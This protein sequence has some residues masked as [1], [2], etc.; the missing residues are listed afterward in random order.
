[1]T[2]ASTS[3]PS[4]A[5]ATARTR[6]VTPSADVNLTALRITSR[7]LSGAELVDDDAAPAPDEVDAGVVAAR[8]GPPGAATPDSGARSAAIAEGSSPAPPP[9]GCPAYGDGSRAGRLLRLLPAYDELEA[10]RCP[11]TVVDAAAGPA[12][13]GE[14]PARVDRDEVEADDVRPVVVGGPGEG[15]TGCCC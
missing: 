7:L 12:P 3:R 6:V 13:Y 10:L 9:Y 8:R 4:L 14:L 11:E 15:R 5:S 2:L 1:M